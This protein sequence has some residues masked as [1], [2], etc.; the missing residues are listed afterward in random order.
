MRVEVAQRGLISSSLRGNGVV[1]HHFPVLGG[2]QKHGLI[3]F[4]HDTFLRHLCRLGAM[5]ALVPNQLAAASH[6]MRAFDD[7]VRVSK[8][9]GLGRI[10][11]QCKRLQTCTD[12]TQSEPRQHRRC[13]TAY[14]GQL[15]TSY[16]KVQELPTKGKRTNLRP[17]LRQVF[18]RG[19]RARPD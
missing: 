13:I 16:Q 5:L 2:W 4:E 18:F 17:F 9:Q 11:L 3:R 1:R 15:A 7:A 10:L 8:R 19:P 6:A 14:V 12:L